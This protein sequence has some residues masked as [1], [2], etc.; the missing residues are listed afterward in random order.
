VYEEGSNRLIQRNNKTVILDANGNTISDRGGNKTFDYD[1]QNRMVASYKK[2]NLKAT[3][4]YN[5]LGQRVIKNRFRTDINGVTEFRR[6][7]VFHYD[8]NG[9][10]LGET[11]FNNKGFLKIQRHYIWL[12]N[13]PLA[14]ITETY[15]ND[16]SLKKT[17]LLY[18]HV[19]YLNTPRVAT[20]EN[21]VAVW[22]WSSDAFGMGRADKDP[23][24]D[25]IKHNV[26]LRFPGQYFDSESGLNYNYFRDY[27]RT[28]GRYVQS[29]PIGLVGGIN[30]YGYVG[31]NP[32]GLIDPSGL[33]WVTK[34]HDY[35]GIAN[36]SKA[37][38]D[39]LANLEEGTVMSPKNCRNCTRDVIQEW[40]P[41]PNDPQNA[42]NEC[43]I[44]DPSPGEQRRIEQTFGEYPDDWAVGGQSWHW[45]PSVGSPTYM[46]FN[47]G[48]EG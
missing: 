10:L 4:S 15:K 7:F 39:R 13:L 43:S 14:Q 46:R 21:Q 12:D 22:L 32:V 26:R 24:N 19:D 23:D 8:L 6:K 17:V 1:E 28:T 34:G 33:I 30:T 9:Q 35:H 37:F 25:G 38:T 27:D 42:K 16:G 44:G 45:R 11:V 3:Y 41:H 29:D 20:D 36:W 47:G 5:A 48:D 31:G 18:L 40:V 2:S